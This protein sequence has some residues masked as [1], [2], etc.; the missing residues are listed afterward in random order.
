MSAS[1]GITQVERF[2]T[3]ALGIAEELREVFRQ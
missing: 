3:T 1:H 2:T